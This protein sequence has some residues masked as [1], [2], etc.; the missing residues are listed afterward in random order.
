MPA[1]WFF[2][3]FEPLVDVA[4]FFIF[5]CN[6]SVILFQLQLTGSSFL[7]ALL[8]KFT[9]ESVFADTTQARIQTSPSIARLEC[10]V[11]LR[12]YKN[13]TLEL[14][15]YLTLILQNWSM[16]LYF[17]MQPKPFQFLHG[18]AILKICTKY[19]ADWTKIIKLPSMKRNQ[20]QLT[21]RYFNWHAKQTN[22]IKIIKDSY[23]HLVSM[24]LNNSFKL[25]LLESN[26]VEPLFTVQI[27][28]F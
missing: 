10:S 9:L 6:H 1:V 13:T 15:N 25:F 4:R 12:S 2:L 5:S 20:S 26:H 11:L 18:S 27:R 17:A 23:H 8:T 16:P 28:Q 14:L 7:D 19:I 3:Y 21:Y 22:P 24:F